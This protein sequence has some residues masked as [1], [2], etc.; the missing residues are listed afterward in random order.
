[1][2]DSLLPFKTL[3]GTLFAFI[4]FLV[5]FF[6]TITTFKTV[7]LVK[8]FTV[9][10]MIFIGLGMITIIKKI[11]EIITIKEKLIEESRKEN[12]VL[13]SCPEYW[14]KETVT[15]DSEPG[16]LNS[17]EDINQ[18]AIICRNYFDHDG[19]PHYVG[20]SGNGDKNSKFSMN[21]RESDS[22]IKP[23]K[24][25]INDLQ[26]KATYIE[27]FDEPLDTTSDDLQT[28]Y[29]HP[30]N[31]KQGVHVHH[32][33]PIILHDHNDP[34]L[35]HA[36]VEGRYPHTHEMNI[37]GSALGNQTYKTRPYEHNQNWINQSTNEINPNGVEINLT[38]LNEA[39]NK[40]EL[41]KMFHWTE[42]YDKCI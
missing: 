12:I 11:N 34:M 7:P 9:P 3:F 23:F 38:K 8:W 16:M 10:L 30:E 13:S 24:D 39:E 27:G 36:H 33:E 1:M 35:S 42:A 25:T 32:I 41:S 15:I 18:S 2:Y 21:F 5:L 26:N 29:I 40:C 6:V 4:A 17:D 19:T 28:T 14:V 37:K 22:S 20:G 31:I